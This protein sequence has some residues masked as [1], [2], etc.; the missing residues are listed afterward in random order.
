VGFGLNEEV[1]RGMQPTFTS[2]FTCNFT[3]LMNAESGR[4]SCFLTRSLPCLLRLCSLCRSPTCVLTTASKR[5]VA[6]AGSWP[7]RERPRLCAACAATKP[8]PR[9]CRRCGGR[10]RLRAPWEGRFPAITRAWCRPGSSRH[11]RETERLP[12]QRPPAGHARSGMEA[13]ARPNSTS[14]RS[15]MRAP[16][17]RAARQRRD[18]LPT[19]AGTGQSSLTPSL[20]RTSA[21]I[22]PAQHGKRQTPH[23][24]VW[25]FNPVCRARAHDTAR[26]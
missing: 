18:R 10:S 21:S 17:A 13:A 22:A 5:A 8:R 24:T 3:R 4:A 16:G 19:Q 1:K 9:S 26:A 20:Y 25:E 14:A 6:A 15:L 23:G 2:Y 11:G 7:G 12:Q